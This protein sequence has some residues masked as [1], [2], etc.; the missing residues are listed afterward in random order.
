MYLKERASGHLV[1]V[2]NFDELFSLFDDAVTGRS[3]YGEEAQD[4]EKFSKSE[5]VFLS[6]EPLPRCWTDPEYRD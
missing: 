2:L 6:G 4:P 3:H 5:L 1:E